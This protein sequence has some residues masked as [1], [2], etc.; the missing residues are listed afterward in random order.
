MERSLCLKNRTSSLKEMLVTACTLTIV[1]TFIFYFLDWRNATRL[2]SG[3]S[4]WNVDLPWDELIPFRPQWVW[5]YLLYFPF[6][7]LPLLFREVRQDIGVFRKVALGFA[8]QFLIA[9]SLF[10][11]IPVYMTRPEISPLTVSES[12]L[13]WVYSIDPGFNILPSLHVAN[14]AFLACLTFRLKGMIPGLAAWLFCILTAVS[15]VFV[16]QHY[17]VDLPAGLLLGVLSY[18]LIFSRTFDFLSLPRVWPSTN[19]QLRN[20]GSLPITNRK[21]VKNQYI[22]REREKVPREL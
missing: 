5:M 9:F 19:F 1:L 18:R 8:A 16:K 12:A 7:F 14:T 17:L 3:Q 21:N 11:F 13:Y 2:V 20:L 22:K 10:F 15:A 4:F 6:C